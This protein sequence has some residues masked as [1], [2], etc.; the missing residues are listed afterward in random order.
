MTT[1][2]LNKWEVTAEEV[3]IYSSLKQGD[4]IK[5]LYLGEN[6]GESNWCTIQ[7]VYQNSFLV[8]P[9]PCFF[10]QVPPQMKVDFSNIKEFISG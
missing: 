4:S 3:R 9:E 7:E 10:Y 5:V 2:T 6:G 8:E 1:F